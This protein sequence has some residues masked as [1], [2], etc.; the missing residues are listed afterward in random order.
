[1][2]VIIN[3]IEQYFD[4]DG[5]PLSE[6][7]LYFGEV[8][9]N[10]VTQ[11]VMVYFDPE[12]TIPAAQPVR[13]VNGYPVRS[14]TAMGLYAPQDV[15][16]LV[17][18]KNMEQVVYIESSSIGANQ[19]NT[20]Y[21]TSD[22]TLTSDDNNRTYIMLDSFT[23]TFDAAV[24]LG[25]RW[26]VNIINMSDG[27][28]TLDPNL[29]ETIDGL[30]SLQLQPNSMLTVYCNGVNL[31]TTTSVYPAATIP[32]AATLD[33]RNVKPKVI[34]IT[35][36][37][38]ISTVQMVNGDTIVAIAKGAFT[39]VDSSNLVVQG[40]VNFTCEVDDVIVFTRNSD[41]VVYAFCIPTRLETET[42]DPTFVSTSSTRATV[43]TWV[44]G[45]LRKVSLAINQTWQDVTSSHV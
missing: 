13:T 42:T 37:S 1:M 20:F 40:G 26:R 19:T 38:T 33:L 29:S 41:G 9:G 43:P 11:P 27:S 34:S 39:I 44:T 35:G 4:T 15:S 32:S 5:S 36:A 12:F 8:Y 6:G 18:N 21:R 3:P 24:T 7:F 30:S 10:P 14:G 22:E 31:K 28:I 23:Q 2:S 25:D 17:Q 45:Y 16:I